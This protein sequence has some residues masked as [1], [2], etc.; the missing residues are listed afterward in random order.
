MEGGLQQQHDTYI[1]GRKQ[2]FLLNKV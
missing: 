1:F 2:I